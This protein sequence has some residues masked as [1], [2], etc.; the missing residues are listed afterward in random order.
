M[1]V[2]DVGNPGIHHEFVQCIEAGARKIDPNTTEGQ[3]MLAI[4]RAAGLTR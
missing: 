3:Y 1:K 2:A 4:L